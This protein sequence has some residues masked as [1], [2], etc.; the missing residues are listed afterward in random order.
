MSFSSLLSFTDSAQKHALRALKTIYKGSLTDDAK[1]KQAREQ[2]DKFLSQQREGKL[3]KASM[4]FLESAVDKS[5]VAFRNFA[6]DDALVPALM[7]RS[8]KF[9]KAEALMDAMDIE[10]LIVNTT[11]AA[12]K[13]VATGLGYGDVNTQPVVL[14]L[15]TALQEGK[16]KHQM[17]L[18]YAEG[19]SERCLDETLLYCNTERGQR[20]MRQL[21]EMSMEMMRGGLNAVLYDDGEAPSARTQRKM[22]KLDQ[23]LELTGTNLDAQCAQLGMGKAAVLK[24]MAKA[25]HESDLDDAIT[26][27]SS[28]TGRELYALQTKLKGDGGWTYLARPEVKAQLDQATKQMLESATPRDPWSGL[29]TQLLSMHR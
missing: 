4:Q 27:Q 21:P 25:C 13:G 3:F 28:D 12:L 8:E 19:L 5:D 17:A 16:G 24:H 10:G 29:V 22:A 11:E 6:V 18:T 26:W 15:R 9:R 20:M 2:A 1:H 23:L 7:A 14:A